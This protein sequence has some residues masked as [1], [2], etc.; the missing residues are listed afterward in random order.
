MNPASTPDRLD[1]ARAGR[2]DAARM[3]RVDISGSGE[4]LVL[5]HGLATTRSIWRHVAPR[6]AATRQS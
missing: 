4:P 6:L 1:G 3:T 5:I 2:H